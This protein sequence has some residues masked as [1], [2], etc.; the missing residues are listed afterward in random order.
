MLLELSSVISATYQSNY[1]W[2]KHDQFLI[3]SWMKGGRMSSQK[4]H[5]PVHMFWVIK[6]INSN[7]LEKM[8][9]DALL[10]F[11]L[12][13]IQSLVQ[14]AL[15]ELIPA[16]TQIPL[17]L[18]QT[19]GLPESPFYR[20]EKEK[21]LKIFTNL[22]CFSRPT[23]NSTYLK[24][25]SSRG[26]HAHWLLSIYIFCPFYLFTLVSRYSPFAHM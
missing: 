2:N 23:H 15:Q 8:P 4:L 1:P 12:K 3:W 16:R 5:L 10:C 26:I 11:F 13:E 14:P 9:R 24:E 7:T 18:L 19:N 21:N 17:S 22:K 20:T 25:R 6:S